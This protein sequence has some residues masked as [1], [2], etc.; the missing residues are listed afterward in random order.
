MKRHPSLQRF[1]REHHRA[2]ILWRNLDKQLDSSDAVGQRVAAADLWDYWN[3][4]FL[5]HMKSEESLL[6]D[7]LNA[8][9]RTRLLA[10]HKTMRLEFLSM[11]LALESNC[12]LGIDDVRNLASVLRA[13][14]RWEERVVFPYLQ[15]HVTEQDLRQVATT[16]TE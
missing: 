8:P 3:V 12:E 14:I 2:L 11:G 7:L 15:C 6:I 16:L 1:S 13:H 4:G 5:I 10:E 9:L